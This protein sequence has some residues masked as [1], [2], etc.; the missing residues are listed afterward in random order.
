MYTLAESTVKKLEYFEMK[1][2]LNKINII[3]TKITKAYN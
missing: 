3:L 2:C 1:L